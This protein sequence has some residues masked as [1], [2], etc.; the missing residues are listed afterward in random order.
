MYQCTGISVYWLRLTECAEYAEL[1]NAVLYIINVHSKSKKYM[2]NYV[3]K[4]KIGM[5]IIMCIARPKST[6]IIMCIKPKEYSPKTQ[7][8]DCAGPKT[9]S[10]RDW[11]FERLGFWTGAQAEELGF[12]TGAHCI[13]DRNP[14]VDEIL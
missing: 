9:Q 13:S 3:H 11:V 2:H 1:L 7:S 5:Y 12:W 8:L 6:C 4:T 14:T 10:Q